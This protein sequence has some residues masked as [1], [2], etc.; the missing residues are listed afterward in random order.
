MTRGHVIAYALAGLAAL[1]LVAIDQNRHFASENDIYMLRQVQALRE[2]A[3]WRWDVSDPVA[4]LAQA[5]FWMANLSLYFHGPMPPLLQAVFLDI[6]QAIGGYTGNQAFLLSVGVLHV[7]GTLLFASILR[8]VGIGPLLVLVGA[9]ALSLSP[10]WLGVS[11]G[12]GASWLS[13]V[14][15]GQCFLVWSVV[16]A[17]AGAR[18]SAFFVALALANILLSDVLSPFQIGALFVGVIA[19]GRSGRDAM[20]PALRSGWLL[21]PVACVLWIVATNVFVLARGAHNAQQV[22][23]FFYPVAQYLVGLDSQGGAVGTIGWNWVDRARIIIFLFGPGLVPTAILSVSSLVL[24]RPAGPIRR[25]VR[26]VSVWAI[27]ASAGFGTIFLGFSGPETGSQAMPTVGY[28]VYLVAPG[29]ALLALGLAHSSRLWTV[30]ATMFAATLWLA[31]TSFGAWVYVWRVDLPGSGA[32]LTVRE[33]TDAVGFRYPDK[34][35]M[36]AGHVVRMAIESAP[37]DAGVAVAIVAESQHAP[38]RNILF[39]R[40]GAIDGGAFERSGRRCVA[41][42]A[43]DRRG[44]DIEQPTD[45]PVRELADRLAADCSAQICVA[46]GTTDGP[47]DWTIRVHG[48]AKQVVE[49]LGYGIARPADIPDN[50]QS[51]VLERAAAPGELGLLASP[52]GYMGMRQ[53]GRAPRDPCG[54]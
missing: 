42:A 37:E 49:I 17:M 47:H 33:S 2:L 4:T 13:A 15:F 25:E 48:D 1:L 40:A 30:R 31:A 19:C 24:V 46:V 32:L 35:V 16:R 7:A 34:G 54:Q 20:M 11:R 29:T 53:S 9:L 5:K 18:A 43:I 44:N 6:V 21:L 28:P 38:L 26:L 12:F 50:A 45:R 52:I 27:V 23:L 39:W 3:P 10:M 41:R 36:G 51:E 8:H 22:V 14:V